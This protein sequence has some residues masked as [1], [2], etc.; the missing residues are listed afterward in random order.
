MLS[1]MPSVCFCS[2]ANNIHLG[3]FPTRTK[4]I[5]DVSPHTCNIRGPRQSSVFHLPD[6]DF[7][8]SP[9]IIFWGGGSLSESLA[10]FKYAENYGSMVSR[11]HSHA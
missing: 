8:I 1:A 6:V 5:G 11:R 3:L 4:S 7:V 2:M 10:F 9:G